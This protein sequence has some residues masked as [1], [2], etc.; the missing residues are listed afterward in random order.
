MIQCEI[1]SS[2]SEFSFTCDTSS[3]TK[4]ITKATNVTSFSK[5]L[6][7]DIHHIIVA[8]EGNMFV[9]GYSSET[10]SLFHV[11]GISTDGDGAFEFEP[12][13][14]LGLIKNRSVMEYE[15]KQGRLNFKVTKGKYKGDLV[16]TSIDT[17]RVHTLN[18][19]L[20]KC[21]T[22]SDGS[23]LSGPVL[24]T[25]RKAMRMTHLKDFYGDD[26]IVCMIRAK[27]GIIDVSSFDNFHMAYYKAK[28]KSKDSFKLALPVVMF[29]L[30]DRFI[31][32][33]GEDAQFVMGSKQFSVMGNTYI[34]SLP[35][36]QVDDEAFDQVPTY[37]K[38]LKEPQ[39]ELTFTGEGIKT[40]DNMFTI[41]D[42]ESKLVMEVKTK[43][44]VRISMSTD[45]GK[46]SD[47]FK[48]DVKGSE[49]MS[50]MIDPRVFSDLF[51][52][53]RQDK[54]IPLKLY[55]KKNKGVTSCFQIC[56]S[57]K[58]AKLTLVGTY[59]DE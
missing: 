19:R 38:S 36:I 54:E 2:T 41:S 16:T 56:S 24:E 40:V 7:N 33:E 21:S 31:S 10:F 4:A 32:D 46:I 3:L 48:T 37:L 58:N 5:C 13:K 59:Y 47:A 14:L 17:D 18:Q 27:K 9:I 57:S 12:K 43:G 53:V 55:G 25:L 30:I 34:I 20:K 23:A 1:D 26:Q 15:F 39:A 8:H 35:P 50:L 22:Q 51:D 45:S 28:T 49:D 52:K 42:A 11:V 6:E 44:Q 29:N